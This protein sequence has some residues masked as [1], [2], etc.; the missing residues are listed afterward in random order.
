MEGESRVSS[1]LW[2]LGLRP[3]LRFP[4]PILVNAGLG[5]PLDVKLGLRWVET[6]TEV[7]A[8]LMLLLEEEMAEE[9]RE[10]KKQLRVSPMQGA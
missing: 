9:G 1:G 7:V 5:F 4:L 10:G 3:L 6:S 2:F 8:W